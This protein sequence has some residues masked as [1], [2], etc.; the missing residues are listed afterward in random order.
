M[1]LPDRIILLHP[2]A[3]AGTV[4]TK[5]TGDTYCVEKLPGFVE[6]IV[7]GDYVSSRCHYTKD[8]VSKNT[9]MWNSV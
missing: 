7:A 6:R 2:H 3:A 5:Y 9:N 8:W 1:E 4:L